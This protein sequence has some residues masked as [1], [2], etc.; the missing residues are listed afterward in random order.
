MLKQ[1]ID[2]TKILYQ[3][4]NFKVKEIDEK[5]HTIEG[6]FSTSAEDRH[7][8]VIDQTGWELKGFMDNPVIL[9]GHDQNIPAIGKAI[10]LKIDGNGNLAGTIQFAVEEHDLAKTIFNLYKG[11]FMRAF[12]V[13][14]RNNKYEVDEE[15]EKIILK[16]NTLYEISCVNVPANAYALAKS[17][18]IDTEAIDSLKSKKKKKQEIKITDEAIESIAKKINDNIKN[19]ISSDNAGRQKTKKVETPAG[20]G[21]RKRFATAKQINQAIRV[22]LKEKQKIKINLS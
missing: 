7:E 18:G 4:L 14:F 6:V 10:E 16:E 9:F 2:K 19:I 15:E 5:A 17:V 12:S 22:L 13:G 11:K 3:D 20:K 1:K 21:R 8:E